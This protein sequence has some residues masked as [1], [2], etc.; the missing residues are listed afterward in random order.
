MLEELPEASFLFQAALRAF[1]GSNYA[2]AI[3]LGLLAL[4]ARLQQE[5][6]LRYDPA[7]TN[8]EYYTDLR[9]QP[10]LADLFVEVARPYERVWYGRA[11]ADHGDAEAV[12]RRCEAVV[13]REG[14]LVA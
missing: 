10:G 1:A 11:A 7:R 5:G 4:I 8:R 12:L 6:L 9:P 2:D 14:P 3:R 13:N